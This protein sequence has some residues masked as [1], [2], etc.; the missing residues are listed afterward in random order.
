M[1]KLSILFLLIISFCFTEDDIYNIKL[2][3]INVARC[4]INIQDTI[5]NNSNYIKLKYTVH[6]SSM[7]KWFFNVD[8]YYETIINKETFDILYFKKNTSQPRVKNE[9]E[10]I[11]VN[12]SVKYKNSH[13]AINKGE[14]NIFSLLY[15]LSINKGN[16]ILD[17]INLDREGKKYLCKIDFNEDNLIYTLKFNQVDESDNGLILN[18]DIFSWALFLDDTIKNI[19]VNHTENKIDSCKF[20]KGLMSFVAKRVDSN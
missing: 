7:M 15:L 19:K 12:G 11:L 10:T 2:Y 17:Q 6:S 5:I 8:N 14:Y 9:C 3:G 16:N 4:T 18:T 20:K 1:K 13:Y